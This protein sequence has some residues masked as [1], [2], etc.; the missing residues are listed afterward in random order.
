MATEPVRKLSRNAHRQRIQRQHAGIK[1]TGPVG[2]AVRVTMFGDPRGPVRI[3][4]HPPIEKSSMTATAAQSL[5][6]VRSTRIR[7]RNSRVEAT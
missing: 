7:A 5:R 4:P 1:L 6:R 3:P 2:R